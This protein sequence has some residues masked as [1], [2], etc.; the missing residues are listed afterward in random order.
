MVEKSKLF[1]WLLEN[2][3]LHSE[4]V[5]ENMNFITLVSVDPNLI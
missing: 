2:W 1:N 4:A 5:T 3:K